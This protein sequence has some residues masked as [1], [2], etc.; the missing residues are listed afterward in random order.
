[1]AKNHHPLYLSLDVEADGPIPG[2]FS[3][4]QF[5]V[6][7]FDLASETPRFPLT[8]FESNLMTL[9]EASTSR[10]TMD[11]WATQGGAYDS[12]RIKAR[13]PGSEMPRFLRWIK[14]LDRKVIIVGYPVTYD[15]M[16][17]YWYTLAFG[18]L[19][20]GERCPF[21]FSGLDIKTLAAAKMGVPYPMASKRR[22]PKRW[23]KGTPEHN[24]DGLTD[25]IGQGVLF[26]NIMLD[27][28]D[29]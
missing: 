7:A 21:G 6:A 15:F 3:M 23:F 5:G 27:R 13:P 8:S 20:D 12:T 24:H 26:V 9:D 25:A 14:A 4:L 1:M 29:G 17:L 16:F 18:G 22:M 2:R 10:S 19:E 11:W 28:D